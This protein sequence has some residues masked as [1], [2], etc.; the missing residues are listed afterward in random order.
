MGRFRRM[1]ILPKLATFHGTVQDHFN[2]ERDLISRALYRKSRSV[3]L[4][5]WQAIMGEG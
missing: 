2:Q 4:K 5:E 3:A 1:K